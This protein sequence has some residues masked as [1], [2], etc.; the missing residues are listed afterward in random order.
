M[1]YCSILIAALILAVSPA[2]AQK[3][4]LRKFFREYRGHATTFKLG[5][6]RVPLK[7][8]SWIVPA[9]AME[10]DGVPLKHI[11]SR[12]QHVKIYTIASDDPGNSPVPP[13]AVQ[14]LRN[15][16]INKERFE[17]LVEVRHEGSQVYLLNKGKED[18]LGNV[19]MLVQDDG[20]FVI[21]NL[22]TTLE[23]KYVNSL[24]QQ[25]AKN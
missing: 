16:L 8:A 18:E 20:E 25:F 13:E 14:R 10:E 22:R 5:I 3:K 23:M 2:M 4:A 1:K 7:F 9:S 15:T 11:L 21:V 12:V 19:V 17:P 6:S 24:I